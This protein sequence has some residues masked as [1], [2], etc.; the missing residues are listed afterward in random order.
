MTIFNSQSST[1]FIQSPGLPPGRVNLAG[2]TGQISRRYPKGAVL[3]FG[4]NDRQ[5]TVN[6]CPVKNSHI[7]TS[8]GNWAAILK[9][10]IGPIFLL[11]KYDI[12]GR[13]CREWEISSSSGV[14][15]EDVA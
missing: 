12:K 7:N 9:V 1:P 15:I 10:N 4:I 6:K 8:F 11:Y 5:M 2:L 3:N 14:R 13:D